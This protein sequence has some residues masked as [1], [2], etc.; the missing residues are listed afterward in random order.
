MKSEIA[1]FFD[2][3]PDG[4][5]WSNDNQG[6]GYDV[7]LAGHATPQTIDI[8]S[9]Q[10]RLQRRENARVARVARRRRLPLGASRCSSTYGGQARDL[11]PWLADAEINRDS[12]LR[13]QY[14][15]GM[16]LNTYENASIYDQMLKYRKFPENLFTGS[17]TDRDLLRQALN[18]P[19]GP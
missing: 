3:F 1:T 19:N 6:K 18:G 4:T 9:M 13:L 2:V 5:V 7:V 14:L 17:Q 11:A 8:D 15:A 10:A 16:S 12:N